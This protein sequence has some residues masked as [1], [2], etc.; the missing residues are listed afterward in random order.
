MVIKELGIKRFEDAASIFDKYDW[1]NA[2]NVCGH[3]G[4][5]RLN[6]SMQLIINA[7]R[8]RFGR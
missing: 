7:V 2:V 6:D 5:K 8:D 1:H 4:E 3:L